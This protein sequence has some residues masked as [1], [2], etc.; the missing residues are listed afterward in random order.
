[1]FVCVFFFGGGGQTFE[2]KT[3]MTLRSA[4][5]FDNVDIYQVC[6]LALPPLPLRSAIINIV[7]IV[8]RTHVIVFISLSLTIFYMY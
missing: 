1:M 7:C 2:R 8:Y 6:G 4:C 3:I 5:L